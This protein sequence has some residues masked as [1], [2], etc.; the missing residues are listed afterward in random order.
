[1]ARWRTPA[2]SHDPRMILA[3]IAGIEEDRALTL[4]LAPLPEFLQAI[5]SA[6]F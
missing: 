5:G 4:T 2:W 3:R 1:M 6:R